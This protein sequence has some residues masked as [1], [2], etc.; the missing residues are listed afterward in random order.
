[1]DN[2]DDDDD[3]D[4]DDVKGV[5]Q[6]GVNHLLVSSLWDHFVHRGLY[7]CNHHHS[8][9]SNHD[10]ILRCKKH[11]LIYRLEKSKL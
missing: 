11:A 4:D 10:T 9:D 2:H 3:D 7:C 6:P 8:C 5:Q 1:M